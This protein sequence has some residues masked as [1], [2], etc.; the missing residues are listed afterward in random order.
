MSPKNDSVREVKFRIS[1]FTRMWSKFLVVKEG[2]A[3]ILI[4][5]E[6]TL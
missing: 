5:D 1:L 2:T 3:R 4:Y 6:H